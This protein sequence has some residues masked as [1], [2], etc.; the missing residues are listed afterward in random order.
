MAR[1]EKSLSERIAEREKS[2]K[3]YQNKTAFLAIRDEV[4]QALTDDW[5]VKVIWETLHAEKKISFGYDA[6]INYVNRLIRRAQTNSEI[7]ENTSQTP[8]KSI[9]KKSPPSSSLS[10]FRFE[11]TPNKKDLL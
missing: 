10:G 1:S 7:S 9:T 3:N 6:F 8:E 2:K 4:K 5:P 11:S